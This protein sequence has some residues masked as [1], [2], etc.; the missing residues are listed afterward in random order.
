M[1][2][3]YALGIATACTT[4][5]IVAVVALSLSHVGLDAAVEV[6]EG[7][8]PVA[9]LCQALGPERAPFRRGGAGGGGWAAERLV[10]QRDR[11]RGAVRAADLLCRS[12]REHRRRRFN[13]AGRVGVPG[14]GGTPRGP[15]RRS[16]S[17]LPPAG[18]SAEGGLVLAG[19]QR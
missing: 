1:A 6:V 12:Q 8:W 15:R 3:A 13:P 10:A 7:A 18:P 17:R 16:T 4:Q 2:V 19:H 11:S 9:S 14:G 5:E